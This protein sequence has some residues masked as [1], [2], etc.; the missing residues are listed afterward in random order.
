M[1]KRVID[2][3]LCAVLFA[4]CVSAEAQQPK[5]I[6]RIGYIM[7]ASLQSVAV[8]YEAFRQGLHELGYG[9][10]KNIIIEYRSAEG[11]PD[12]FPMILEELARLKVEV[13]VT[14]GGTVTR[15]AKESGVTMP[16]VMA[17]DSDP[18]GNGFVASLARPSGTLLDWQI[19][20]LR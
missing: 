15:A 4:L 17:N 7:N 12:R 11:K 8:R 16:I 18:V 19:I 9:D 5:K 13:I 14:G 10:G 20:A 3:S 6:P 2:I 1:R